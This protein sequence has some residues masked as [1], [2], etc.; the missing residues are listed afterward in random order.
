MSVQ[1]TIATRTLQEETLHEE[2]RG[3]NGDHDKSTTGSNK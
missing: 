3:L 1:I 2:V